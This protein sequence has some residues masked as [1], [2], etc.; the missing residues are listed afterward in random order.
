MQLKGL[1]RFFAI[2]LTLICLYQLSFTWFVRSHE[3]EMDKK[4]T[5]WLKAMMYP[6]VAAIIFITQLLIGKM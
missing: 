5:V 6:L 4:A 2:A 3:S 1:V